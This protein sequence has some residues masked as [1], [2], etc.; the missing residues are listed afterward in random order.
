M[1]PTA[2]AAGLLALIAVAALVA[3]LWLVVAGALVLALAAAIDGW[4]VRRAPAIE[5]AVAE[6]L[7]RGVPTPLTA[8]AT[9]AD[10]RRVLLRQAPAAGIEVADPFA[11]NELRSVLV[12]TRRGRHQLP[13]VASASVG[14]LGLARVHHREQPAVVLRVYPDLRAARRL[15]LR[16]RRG[17]AGHPGRLARGPLGLNTDFEAIREYSPDDDIRQLNWRATARLG[18]PLSNQ[19]RVQRDRDVIAMID[20]GRLMNAPLGSRT[21]LDAAMDVLTVIALAADELGDRFGAIAFD[22]QVR[23]A[24]APRHLGGA[25]AVEAMFDLQARPVDS[26]FERAFSRVQRSRR[27]LVLVCTDL[28]DEAAARSLLAGVPVIAR[29][30]AVLVA[31]ATDPVLERLGSRPAGTGERLAAQVVAA[32]VLAARAGAAARL[33]G[34]GAQV[35]EAPAP[36]LPELCLQAY[37][38]AKARARL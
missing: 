22:D 15:V 38:R 26:D 2:R 32:D 31:G 7:S 25:A 17:F 24:L 13:G 29:R 12:A 3:P 8:R 18:R 10:R 20:C 11:V 34:S 9:P 14:P 37:V 28:V 21:M 35:L 30:H 23:V 33:R 5:Y 4:S 16:L 19:Y 36:A 1:V 27:G 6:V